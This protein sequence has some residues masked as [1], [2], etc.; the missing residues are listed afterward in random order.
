M[1]RIRLLAT[2]LA[3]ALCATTAAQA[4]QFTGVISFGDS[5][6]DAGNIAAMNGL[7]PGFGFTTNP[8]PVTVELIAK[9][10]GFNL[11]NYSPLV[12]GSSGTDFAYGGACVQPNSPSFTCVNSPGAFSLTTQVNGYIAGGH[13]DPN[14]LYTMWGGANDLFTYAALAAGGGGGEGGG[15]AITGQQALAGVATSAATETGLINALQTAGARNIIVFNLPNIAVTPAAAAQAQAAG[16]AAAAAVLAGGGT[17]AQAAAAAQAAGA[18][19]IQSL[20][21]LSLMY[22]T[23]LNQGMAGRTGIIP[24][25]VFGLVNEVLANPGAYGFTNTTGMACSTGPGV[26]GTPSSVACGPA[27]LAGHLPYTYAPGTDLSYFFADGVHPTGA[28]H[29][30]LAQAVVSEIQA[31]SYT[32]MLAEAPLQVFDIQNRAI[33][34]QMQADMSDRADGSLRTFA[35]YDYSHQSF[36]ATATSPRM[37][38]NSNSL[39]IGADYN[40]NSAITFGMS[41]TF[42]HQDASFGNGGGF[43]NNEPMGAAWVVWHTPD[44]YL[45]ALG[46]VGQLNFNGINRVIQLGT[47]TRIESGSTSGSHLGGELAGGYWFHFDD[48]KTGPFASVSHQRVHVGSYFENGSDS[49]TMDFGAQTRNS[50]I[51]RLGWDLTGDTKA[52]GGTFHPF[53]RVAYNHESDAGPRLVSAGLIG[54]N[55]TFSMPGYQPNSS[56]WTGQL[57]V[58]ASLGGNFSGFA[59]YDG[60]FGDSSQRIDSFN[61]GV[62]MSW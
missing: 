43:Q 18:Q 9:A 22:N 31:P 27:S 11:T 29:A 55:G 19:V 37:T 48:L 44:W 45:S 38:N 46:S 57:G 58:A 40:V 7:P 41:T 24:V 62:K 10:F 3:L 60:H 51:W 4:Q 32:S 54:L 14:A 26:G 50:T 20:T 8:D 35:S 52:F 47:A 25:N 34:G 49:L 15:P 5:L 6:S 30:L 2:S 1:P 12:P 59:S 28:A 13:V 16:Q 17:P 61:V 39:V 36:D 56:Y 21:G 23:T 42:S 33:R 53:A